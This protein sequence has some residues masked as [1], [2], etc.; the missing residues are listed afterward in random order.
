MSLLDDI[1]ERYQAAPPEERKKL[2][3]A[4][5]E[6]TRGMVWIPTAGPQLD[7][8]QSEADILLYGGQG[9]G[10]K[11]S[12]LDSPVLTPFGWR[13]IGA[14]KVG[15]RICATDGSTQEVIAVCP[16]GVKDIYRC[17]MRDGGSIEV[18]LEHLW[19]AW[20]THKSSKRSNVPA[21]GAAAAR[22]FTTQLMLDEM[23]KGALAD[24]TPRGFGVPV[25]APVAFNVAGELVG[26]GNFVGRPVDPYFLGLLIGDG[27]LGNPRSLAVTSMDDE[28]ASYL[29]ALAQDDLSE[30]GKEGNQAKSYRFI[31][32]FR[33]RLARDLEALGLLGHRAG[34]KAIP[35]AYLM[36]DVATRWALIQGLMDTDGWVEPGRACYYTTISK[37]LAD[38]FVF[39]ARSLGGV[40][41]VTEKSPTYTGAAGEKLEGQKAYCV[42]VRIANPERLFR[43]E[44][45][46]SVAALIEHQS[47]GRFIEAIE[48][49]RRAEAVCIAVSHPNSLYIG[50]D[51]IVTHN[52]DLGLGLA[53]TR[54]QRSLI[55]R[56]Q[57]ANLSSITER[58]IK[59]HGTRQGF[60]G[61]P[62]PLLRTTDG[63]YIQ[64]GA[65]QHPG[66]EENW[67]GH[68]FDYKYFDEAVQ[69]LESQVRFH[70]GW[71]RPADGA[72]I[73]TR[74]VLGT[75]PPLTAEGDWIIKMFRPWL[76]ITYHRPAKHGELRWFIT[77]PEGDEVEIDDADLG[78]KSHLGRPIDVQGRTY[79][80]MS[81][82]FIPAKLSD[83]PYLARTDY[84]AKLDALPEPIRSAVRDGN[85][86]AARRD[87]E[88]QVIPAQW[89]MEAQARWHPKGWQQFNMTCMGFDPAGGGRDSAELVWRH[90]D[91][92][93]LFE[94]IK[95]PET[96]DGS[97]A[98]SRIMKH[99]RDEAAICIDVGGGFA[100][101]TVLRM[102][103][104]GIAYMPFNGASGGV[105]RTKDRTLGFHNKRAEAWWK[106][107]EALDPDQEG[108]S[109]IQLPPDPEV[110]ADL[111]API[112]E[113]TS[114]G[115]LIESKDDLRKRLGRSP[116]KGD[117]VVMCNYGGDVA[118]KRKFNVFGDPQPDRPKYSNVGYQAQKQRR[119]V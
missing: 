66:D 72:D 97:A 98:F 13:P 39:L 50:D 47:Q 105:G 119:R 84:Q 37:Q 55:L 60:S 30:G 10:G 83:N 3:A 42:R 85:F 35:R 115:I 26:F 48:Y 58:A 9:G 41:S 23:R 64:F 21:M 109:L 52:T 65:N 102:K 29:R 117:A 101:A 88:F 87:A 100:S 61:A 19:L 40:T 34:S 73:R 107:R 74:A 5:N 27:S 78:P 7:A 54:H 93:S 99:R 53:F 44:R 6:A 106:F 32:E 51:Y 68:P 25:P 31:G 22:K 110:L 108:G 86:M 8:W 16:Q 118:I 92:Y 116:G 91:W 59:I 80:A 76:D 90:G 95:G 49:S 63:R 43:L 77:N 75:N 24:G 1:L 36:A 81:R 2:E 46:R 62:P 94:S 15:S 67:Q 33:L 111:T 112:Y 28:I 38:D 103:D 57:Y 20:P 4:A 82:T 71:L 11:L 69:F 114:K 113:L 104:N 79:Y 96:A 56:R 17:H 12:P 14:L 18:G 45:K 89:V 70:L